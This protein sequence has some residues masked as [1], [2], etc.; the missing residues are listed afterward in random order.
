[1]NC[2]KKGIKI[3]TND[4]RKWRAFGFKIFYYSFMRD[5]IFRKQNRYG[6]YFEKKKYNQVCIY[7]KKK[8]SKY[9][10]VFK[11]ENKDFLQNNIESSVPIWIMWWQG[12]KQQPLIVKECIKS[13]K[14]HNGQHKV[15][16]IDKMNISEFINFP[17]YILEKVEKG[18]ISLTE[19]SDITRIGLLKEYGGIWIDSTIFV[20]DDIDKELLD[21]PFFTVKHN[22][23]GDYHICH[24]KWSSF[25]LATNKENPY[26]DF[27]LNFF[28]EYWKNENLLIAYLLIDAIMYIGYEKEIYFKELIDMVPI[29]NT[30]TFEFNRILNHKYNFDFYL[31]IS[32]NTYIYKL[33]YKQIIN[34]DDN[35]NYW[36]NVVCDQ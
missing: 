27:C 1:M 8:Y 22:L 36:N 31:E 5:L 23:M 15:I 11:I 19:L 20:N 29:N 30:K 32:E 16:I 34:Y 9:L 24:G 2:I 33:S 4:F 13:I 35:E 28:Y 18:I 25:F 14:K 26:F 6:K 3:L 21:Y 17:S 10:S 12:E 7:L